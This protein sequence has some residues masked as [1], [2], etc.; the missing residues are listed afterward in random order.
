MRF[1]LEKRRAAVAALVA[2][3]G[4]TALFLG[5]SGAGASSYPCSDTD[6]Q[7]LSANLAGTYAGVD[8]GGA[9]G[10][11]V[12]VCAAPTGGEGSQRWVVVTTGDPG[13]AGTGV[14]V[15]AGGCTGVVGGDPFG[16]GC[17]YL[18]KP[19]GA[20]VDAS[21]LAEPNGLGGGD[22]TGGVVGTPG[23]CTY[24]DGSTDCGSSGHLVDVTVAEG[25]LPEVHT[26]PGC[27]NVNGTCTAPS[28][29]GANVTVFGDTGNET[30]YVDTIAGGFS[31]EHG[32]TC[33]GV[34]DPCP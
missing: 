11:W 33:V 32:S 20:E 15:Q 14:A 29:S 26:A 2:L 7:D 1:L 16:P 27:V 23:T 19:T 25:D 9:N 8:P 6:G 4:A 17:T 28:V 5:A 31:D 21:A 3:L 18:L 24:V 30:V 13:G 34:N 22:G 12:W 10:G